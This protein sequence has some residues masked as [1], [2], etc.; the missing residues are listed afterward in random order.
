MKLAACFLLL[1]P[2]VAVAATVVIV[3]AAIAGLFVLMFTIKG[4]ENSAGYAETVDTVCC[5]TSAIDVAE[6]NKVF[7]VGVQSSIG[8]YD[9][10]GEVNSDVPDGYGVMRMEA[11]SL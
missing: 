2:G 6:R 1:L 10:L 11:T 3:V 7:I 5:D 8:T 4:C 9:Y